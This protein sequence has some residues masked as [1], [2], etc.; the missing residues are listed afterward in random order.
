M[1]RIEHAARIVGCGRPFSVGL[2]RRGERDRA[3]AGD[4]GGHR[5]HHD[6]ADERRES[7]RD[8]QADSRHRHDAALHCGAVC[9]L[10]DDGLLELGLTG[11]AQSLDRRL[12]PGTDVGVKTVG[13]S[14]QLGGVDSQRSGPDPVE[15]F[16][17]LED[18]HLAAL[19]NV[20][21]HG[22]DDSQGVLHVELGAW[23]HP[24]VAAQVESSDHG[25]S[26]RSR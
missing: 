7:T 16:A 21:A 23:Q 12:E 8:V 19:S 18:G 1:P 22:R 11:S 13:G 10:G 5:V 2:W 4:L 17:V 14:G 25:R 6:R 24:V 20:L 26:L 9:H 15:P 3:D